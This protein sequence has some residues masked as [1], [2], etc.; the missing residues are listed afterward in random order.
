MEIAPQLIPPLA[1]ADERV[2][3]LP[4]PLIAADGWRSS[5]F[6]SFL[7]TLVRGNERGCVLAH[8]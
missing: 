7:H 6:I 3:E 1:P 8:A 4:H 2:K 5:S